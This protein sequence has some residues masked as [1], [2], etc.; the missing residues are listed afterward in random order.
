M[1]E[2]IEVGLKE[3]TF[4]PNYTQLIHDEKAQWFVDVLE[5]DFLRSMCLLCY[6]GAPYPPVTKVEYLN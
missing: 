4:N 1:A 2:P 5:D 3:V 6:R